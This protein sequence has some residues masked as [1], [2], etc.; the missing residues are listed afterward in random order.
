MNEFCAQMLIALIPKEE[1]EFLM[2]LKKNF[3]VLVARSQD[4]KCPC[5]HFGDHVT[6]KLIKVLI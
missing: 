1:I 2:N 3:E 6:E 5:R 4:R